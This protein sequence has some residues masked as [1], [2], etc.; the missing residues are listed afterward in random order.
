M[1]IVIT[2]FR[3]WTDQTKWRYLTASGNIISSLFRAAPEE[4]SVPGRTRRIAAKKIL[5]GTKPAAVN[6]KYLSG[7]VGGS[8]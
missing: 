1:S 8:G 4:E 2:R 7:H 3:M 6:R 5:L